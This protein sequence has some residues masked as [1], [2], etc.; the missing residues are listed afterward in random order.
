MNSDHRKCKHFCNPETDRFN[1]SRPDFMQSSYLN[2]DIGLFLKFEVDEATGRPIGCKGLNDRKWLS[3]RRR[4]VREPH[5]CPLNDAL[6][7]EGSKMHEIV[8]EFANDEQVW[9]DEFVAV[10]EKMQE[11]GYTKRNLTIS[12]NTWQGLMCSNNNCKRI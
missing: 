9:I 10:F 4:M 5:G 3:N 11:N 7:I 8:E 2:S 1:C 12:P 6:D